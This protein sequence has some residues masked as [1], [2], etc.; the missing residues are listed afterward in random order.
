MLAFQDIEA[1]INCITSASEAVPLGEDIHLPVIFSA[2][3]FDRLPAGP[4][5]E[6]SH[7][8]LR[9]IEAYEEWF[10]YHPVCVTF[11]LDYVVTAI[12]TPALASLGARVLKALCDLC[13]S[14]LK[15]HVEAFGVLHGRVSSLQ[16]SQEFTVSEFRGQRCSLPPTCS[17][18][19]QP[20][21]QVR[22]IEAITSI[23][24]ALPPAESVQPVVVSFSALFS[25]DLDFSFPITPEYCHTHRRQAPDVPRS[26]IAGVCPPSHRSVSVARS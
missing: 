12:E 21:D 14:E 18:T 24:Q 8:A 11:V 26:S 7:V 25:L 2:A 22:V 15:Q 3:V 17:Q 6:I 23:L 1:T 9:L 10:K 20:L 19:T 4:N 16:V 13:R 5:L